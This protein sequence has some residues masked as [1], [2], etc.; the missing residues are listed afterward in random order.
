MRLD[1]NSRAHVRSEVNRAMRRSLSL[2]ACCSMLVCICDERPA[3]RAKGSATRRW[4]DAQILEALREVSPNGEAVGQNRYD[5]QLRRPDRHPTREV[6]IRR[7]G[8]WDNA[9]EAVRGR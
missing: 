1:A 2:T 5:R 7:F 4:T 3:A 9:W 8:S 6:V